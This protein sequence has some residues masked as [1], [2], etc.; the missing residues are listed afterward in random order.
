MLSSNHLRLQLMR[1][2]T[3]EEW[4]QTRPGFA[5]LFSKG[6]AGECV[7]EGLTQPISQGDVLVLNGPGSAR[8]IPSNGDMMLWNFSLSLEHLFPLFTGSEISLLHSVAERFKYFKHYSAETPIAA[9]CNKLLGEAPEQFNLNH[10]IHLLRVAAS[11][12]TK[13]FEA[14]RERCGGFMRVEDHLLQVFK[15]LTTD[16]ILHLSIDEL[17]H[18]FGCSR[19]HLNRLFH[20]HLKLSVA[21]LKMEMRLL[22]AISLLRDPIAKITD[23]AKSCG[24]HHLG[25]FNTCFRRRF[26][27]SPGEWRRHAVEAECG[28]GRNGRWEDSCPMKDNVLCLW[29]R[30][31]PKTWG[32]VEIP[33]PLTSRK[34]ATRAPVSEPQPKWRTRMEIQVH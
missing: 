14:V 5:F 11:V 21:T 15:K 24:F 1:L 6:G 32:P 4:S 29:A 31:M 27:S 7:T 3:G 10:R 19:R 2:R 28:P 18:R 8:L 13:E 34:Q 25:L 9:E 33:V 12:L 23:V 20:Q 30:H 26:G 22:K 16:D 17:A